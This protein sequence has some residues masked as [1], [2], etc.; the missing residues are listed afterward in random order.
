M[1]CSTRGCSRCAICLP[2]TTM[3]SDSPVHGCIQQRSDQPTWDI[4]TPV[5]RLPSNSSSERAGANQRGRPDFPRPSVAWPGRI[6]LLRLLF[7][8]AVFFFFFSQH[9]C[10]F[11]LA[12]P[13]NIRRRLQ[14][15]STDSQSRASP[16]LWNAIH[17]PATTRTR[18]VPALAPALSQTKSCRSLQLNEAVTI[19]GIPTELWVAT[20]MLSS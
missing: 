4:R 14:S 18:P 16:R 11:S 9:C 19:Y 3:T 5:E 8:G 7:D 6:F 1:Q 10:S 17:H 15:A 20:E 2:P 13:S 12:A